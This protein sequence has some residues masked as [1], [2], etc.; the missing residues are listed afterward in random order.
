MPFTGLIKCIIHLIKQAMYQRSCIRFLTVLQSTEESNSTGVGSQLI[1]S[2][3]DSLHSFLF[4]LICT[5]PHSLFSFSGLTEWRWIQ[6]MLQK[7]AF[8]P[9]ELHYNC[10][11][12]KHCWLLLVK[13]KV[14]R[15]HVKS[16]YIP[17]TNASSLMEKPSREKQWAAYI[18]GVELPQLC[19]RL[20]MTSPDFPIWVMFQDHQGPTS[21]KNSVDMKYTHPWV[22]WDALIFP[23]MNVVTG[24]FLNWWQLEFDGNWDGEG[25]GVWEPTQKC[26]QGLFWLLN[27]D[28]KS[29]V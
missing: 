6:Q 3:A 26:V 1:W 10:N 19:S 12:K 18:S 25:A 17:E 7:I 4:L 23:G 27:L 13:E 11:S 2:L 8:F 14:E 21:A 5:P 22:G 28:R 9:T 15:F 24:N 29:V 16:D 20:S